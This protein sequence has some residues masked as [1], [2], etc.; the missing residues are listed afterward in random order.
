MEVIVI[1]YDLWSGNLRNFYAWMICDEV[2]V[3][4]HGGRR[5]PVW[6]IHDNV[7]ILITFEAS[8]IRAISCYMSLFLALEAAIL[9]IGHHVGCRRWNNHGS[10]ALSFSTLELATLSVCGPF[11]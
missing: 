9:I 7:T 1:Y 3:V 11:S 4:C 10:T 8:N 2:G 6:A 5:Y